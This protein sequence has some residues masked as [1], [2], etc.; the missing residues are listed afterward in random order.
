MA[1]YVLIYFFVINLIASLYTVID[2]SKAKHNKWRISENSLILLGLLG[3]AL[4]EYLTMKLVRHK[5]LHKKFMIGLPLIII[6]H[7]ILIMMIFLKVAQII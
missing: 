3:G 7:T 4:G 2:K 1:K 6:L 5:T